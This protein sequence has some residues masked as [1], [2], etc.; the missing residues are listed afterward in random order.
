MPGLFYRFSF[1]LLKMLC[2]EIQDLST[3]LFD[4]LSCLAGTVGGIVSFGVNL[5][6]VEFDS[7]NTTDKFTKN[8]PFVL[9]EKLCFLW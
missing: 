7:Q 9:E 2:R 1:V 3:H 6:G 5:V 4:G 8:N